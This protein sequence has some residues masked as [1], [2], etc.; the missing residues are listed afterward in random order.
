MQQQQ[1][2]SQ[3]D[4]DMQWKVDF[5]QQLAMI[6][7]VAG[8]RS[9]KALPKAK[10]APKKGHGHCLVVSCSSDPLQLSESQWNHYI[11]EV[12]STNQTDA[13]KTAT[14]AASTGQQKGLN[15]YPRQCATTRHTTNASK[16]E[17]IGLWSFASSTIFTK[18]LANWGP[19]LQVAWQLFAQKML[20]QRKA[21]NAFQEFVESQRTDFYVTGINKL[22]SSSWENV[23]IVTVAI[24][25]NK[26]VLEPSYN[27]LKFTVIDCTLAVKQQQ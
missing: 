23:F 7:S 10:S 4:C 1:T 19:L 21:E 24:L 6:S 22:V 9:S 13:L 17:W 3:S 8:P 25:T 12:C 20:P 15:F 14:L 26:V 27:D 2:I 5:T 16:V 11:W 18:P